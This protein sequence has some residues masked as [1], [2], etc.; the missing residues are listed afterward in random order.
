MIC[1]PTVPLD[2]LHELLHNPPPAAFQNV[3]QYVYTARGQRWVSGPGNT[4]SDCYRVAAENSAMQMIRERNARRQA[5]GKPA[6]IPLGHIDLS[7]LGKC[8]E[9]ANKRICLDWWKN[10]ADWWFYGSGGMCFGD[11]KDPTRLGAWCKNNPE[12]IGDYALSFYQFLQDDAAEQKGQVFQPLQSPDGIIPYSPDRLA[13]VKLADTYRALQAQEEAALQLISQTQT[14]ATVA[15][16]STTKTITDPIGRLILGGIVLQGVEQLPHVA[17]GAEVQSNAGGGHPA[18]SAG[19]GQPLVGH[20]QDHAGQGGGGSGPVDQAQ[21]AH[22][23]AASSGVGTILLGGLA[24][25]AVS[26]FGGK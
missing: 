23:A 17:T 16:I 12:Y 6:L 1:F 5:D 18:Q 3:G 4:V 10:S 9:P 7:A 8:D 13:E 19:V 24:F 26:L 25:A 14:P 21:P 20:E 11:P 15:Q 2:A 22:A